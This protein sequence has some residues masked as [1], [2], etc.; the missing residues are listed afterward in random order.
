[1]DSSSRMPSHYMDERAATLDDSATPGIAPIRIVIGVAGGIAAYKIAH[2]VR[3]FKESGHEVHVVPT[4]T[5]LEFV[6]KAT[7]EALSGNPVYTEVFEGTDEV[8]HVRLGR[9]ADLVVVAPATADLLAR[10]VGGRADDML[11][12]TLLTTTKPVLFAPA[13]HTEMWLHPATQHNV[14]VLRGRGGVVLNPAGG[15]LTG[16]DTGAGRLPEPEEI[17]A[18]AQAVLRVNINGDSPQDLAGWNVAISAG[19]TREALDPVRFLGNRSTGHQGWALAQAAAGRGANVRLI[20]ANVDLATPHGVDRRD[21]ESARELQVEMDA[22]ADWADVVVMAAAVADYRPVA[23]AE[24]KQKK[25][26][27]GSAPTIELEQ[28]PDI[29]AGLV[30]ERERT[31]SGPEL[32]VGFAAETGD[33]SG[34]VLDHARKKAQRKGADLLVVNQVGANIGFGDIESAITVLTADGEVVAE[35][36]GTKAVIADAL[37]DAISVRRSG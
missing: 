21:V 28:N 19:G 26:E 29:L 32:I 9:E 18:A 3:L 31:G 6:G 23:S 27:D 25:P 17:F 30:Q 4:K 33:A 15:R 2:L 22:A 34:S 20:A 24:T 1:M 13:M 14:S 37:W 5:A 10:A 16:K 35:A 8:M 7:W 36:G 12:A 11:T